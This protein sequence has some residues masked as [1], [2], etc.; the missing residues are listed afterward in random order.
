MSRAWGKK[1]LEL[2]NFLCDSQTSLNGQQ[3]PWHVQENSSSACAF[4]GRGDH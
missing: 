1:T 4:V 3:L 2:S